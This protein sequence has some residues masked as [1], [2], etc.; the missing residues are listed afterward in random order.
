MMLPVWG[1]LILAGGIYLVSGHILNR[2]IMPLNGR[3][4]YNLKT[5]DKMRLTSLI[6][7]LFTFIN[8]MFVEKIETFTG[9]DFGNFWF[10]Y[11]MI[12]VFLI[13][14]IN[15]RRCFPLLMASLFLIGCKFHYEIAGYLEVQIGLTDDQYY[16]YLTSIFI[17][18]CLQILLLFW[19]AYDVYKFYRSTDMVDNRYAD[20]HRTFNRRYLVCGERDF[21]KREVVQASSKN[22]KVI[23]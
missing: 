22:K 6:V 13:L 19:G 12:V 5:I 3:Q 4:A 7:L 16:S 9:L 15:G 10:R 21:I 2:A 18:N 14:L 20:K 11:D 17:M 8:I 1:L 23:S